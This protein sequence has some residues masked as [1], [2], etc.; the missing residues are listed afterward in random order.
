M[1]RLTI[2]KEEYNKI[3]E[4]L[5]KRDNNAELGLN[6]TQKHAFL[7][8]LSLFSIKNNCLFYLTAEGERKV[9]PDDDIELQKSIFN[10]L[11]LPD[12]RGMT[13][14]YK[15][16]RE[17]FVGFKRKR[18]YGYVSSCS[19][20]CR[21]QP[22][23][24][25][26]PITPI[27]ANYPWERV[28]MDC[29]DLR[30]HSDYNNGYG[31]ILNIL[32]VYS[33]FIYAIPLKSKCA[34]EI[35]ESFRS[36]VFK[37]G[38]PKYLQTDNGKEFINETL[39]QFLI[40]NNIIRIRGRPRHPQNQ[41]QVERANQTLVRKLS[42]ALA[43]NLN[44]EWIN[45]LDRITFRYNCTWNRAINMTP[46]KAF[47]G[48]NG[49]NITQNNDEKLIEIESVSSNE[50]TDNIYNGNVNEISSSNN[51]RLDLNYRSRYI[52]KMQNDADVH[53]SSLVFNSGDFVLLKL[54]FDN[55]TNSRRDKMKSFYEEGTWKIIE[56]KGE[57]AYKI[58]QNGLIKIVSK[59]R[60][61]KV[62]YE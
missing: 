20:C 6:K 41:G 18:I 21:Y 55:N 45:I 16:S 38:A 29:I 47:R 56:R 27:V 7:K 14:M 30:K 10:D 23:K 17:L 39:N 24:R 33:K 26:Q 15:S 37:E 31:W 50:Q 32:D 8:K 62:T 35:L 2:L 3:L 9:I 1:I 12:H 46:F 4:I 25:N 36:V 60:L 48:R 40:N 11:H 22:L 54:D 34:S 53:F 49:F 43:L 44:K 58:E 51:F 28:Q 52:N 61:K 5:K 19:V 57:D 42:K 13:A 59:L